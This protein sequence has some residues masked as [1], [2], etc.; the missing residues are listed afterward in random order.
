MSKPSSQIQLGKSQ[1]E[2][3]VY[4]MSPLLPKRMR[5]VATINPLS[6]RVGSSTRR[7]LLHNVVPGRARYNCLYSYV[8][9]APVT[10]G[11]SPLTAAIRR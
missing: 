3:P 6:V 1:I 5:G 4:I 7:W 2:L 8:M 9:A 11:R 10:V